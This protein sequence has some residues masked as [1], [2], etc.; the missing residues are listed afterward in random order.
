MSAAGS[1]PDDM[2]DLH[3]TF[4]G[5]KHPLANPIAGPNASGPNDQYLR[6]Q[7]FAVFSELVSQM[8]DELFSL[9]A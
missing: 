2:Q 6:S 1:L 3:P 8:I 4:S 5:A 9:L 7:F